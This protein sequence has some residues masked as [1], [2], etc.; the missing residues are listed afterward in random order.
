MEHNFKKKFG[1]NFITD[2]N[3][4]SAI[5]SDA[6]I[7][8]NALVLEVGAG[9]GTL[10]SKIAEQAKKVI[11]FEI[12][13]ELKPYLE[14]VERKYPNVKIVFRDFMQENILDYTKGE[15]FCVIANLPYYIT[16]AIISKFIETRPKSMTIMVQNEV[17]DRICAKTGTGD[18][19][20]LSVICTSIAKVS[21]TRVVKKEMFTPVPKID[22]A[23]IHFEFNEKPLKED[24]VKFIRG[25]FALKRKTLA[26]NLSVYFNISK[27]EINKLLEQFGLGASV[28]AEQ[29]SCEE[30]ERLYLFFKNE[31]RSN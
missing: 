20:A 13:S 2:G 18:Y 5:V 6:N 12:D 1:Q 14:E 8:K 30:F 24:Y 11:S 17:A 29:I 28:R 26:N 10:T 21:K 31:L 15:E 3:L 7:D 16:T 19:G 4:L 9:A 27:T 25:C 22:S 23:I